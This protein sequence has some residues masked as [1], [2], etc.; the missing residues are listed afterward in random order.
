MTP[1][2]DFRFLVLMF[3][4]AACIVGFAVFEH[5]LIIRTALGGAGVVCGIKLGRIMR[6]ED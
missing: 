2:P 3:G 1:Q 5:H 4:M 6:G